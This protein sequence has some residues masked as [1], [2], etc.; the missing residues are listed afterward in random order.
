MC[1]SHNVSTE[2]FEFNYSKWKLFSNLIG[3]GVHAR[4]APDDVVEA[5]RNGGILHDVAGVDDIGA[6]GR[7]LDLDL[8][9]LTADLRLQ[10]HP[11]QQ[12]SDPFCWFTEKQHRGGDR[13]S[14]YWP[15]LRKK[16][17]LKL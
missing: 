14:I 15:K 1:K 3:Y 16:K 10:T 4:R 2:P 12:L 8:I 17:K 9:A 7:D 11:G 13:G 5:V 6:R